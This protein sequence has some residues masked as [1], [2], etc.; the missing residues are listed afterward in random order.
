MP[1]TKKRKTT[2]ARRTPTRRTPA[3]RSSDTWAGTADA[4]H[5]L[6]VHHATLP[7]TMQITFR[8]LPLGW[9]IVHGALPDHLR[10]LA[11]AEYADPGAGAERM[12]AAYLEAGPEPTDEQLEAA[13][14]TARKIGTDLAELNREICAA[15]LVAPQLTADELADPRVPVE[16][17][18]MLAG[19][20][21]GLV[22]LDAAGRLVGVEP[23]DTFR[24]IREEHGCPSGCKGCSGTRRRL[25]SR[26]V[27]D[28]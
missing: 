14:A 12:H 5:A 22:H 28:L 20:L 26:D 13:D 21:T 11:A 7:S 8:R 3:V 2:P 10:E 4:W 9:L 27:G 24:V 16:D 1:T 18:E 19:F 15:A 23:I 25:S 6:G 17:L